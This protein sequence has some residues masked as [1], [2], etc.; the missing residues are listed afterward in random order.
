MRRQQLGADSPWRTVTGIQNGV[1]AVDGHRPGHR[2]RGERACGRV[3]LLT[4]EGS[5]SSKALTAASRMRGTSS[6]CSSVADASEN[7]THMSGLLKAIDNASMATVGAC[8]QLAP[9][10]L[11]IT[12]LKFRHM[13]APNPDAGHLAGDE[14][15]G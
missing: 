1:A 4:D 6:A 2:E 8:H 5:T 11:R 15:A 12:R 14:R 10:D 7:W 9:L 13:R 3:L